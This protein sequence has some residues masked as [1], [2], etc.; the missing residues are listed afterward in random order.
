MPRC[1]SKKEIQKSLDERVTYM[2]GILMSPFESYRKKVIIYCR[3]HGLM[4]VYPGNILQ[5]HWCKKCYEE[6]IKVDIHKFCVSRALI[7][8]NHDTKD[9]CYDIGCIF[10]DKSKWS[11]LNNLNKEPYCLNCPRYS[12]QTAKEL[13]YLYNC[14]CLDYNNIHC[15]FNSIWICLSCNFTF[16]ES[17]KRAK[18]GNLC[19][20][21]KTRLNLTEFEQKAGEKLCRCLG[22]T[23]ISKDVKLTYE[24][25]C[26]DGKYDLNVTEAKEYPWC[27]KCNLSL[28]LDEIDKTLH[29]LKLDYEIKPE[30][31][32][33]KHEF[34]FE[35]GYRK[36]KYDFMVKKEEKFTL[37][38]YDPEE[39][40]KVTPNIHNSYED[41]DIKRRIEM[42]SAHF[43][44][45]NGY[46]HVR[47]S[48]EERKNIREHI[49]KGLD[50]N[51]KIYYSN[52][53]KYKF[54][55]DKLPREIKIRSKN[56]RGKEIIIIKYIER[57][58]A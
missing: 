4:E 50:S 29:D 55:E 51:E 25:L 48:H 39:F 57:A 58:E 5:G 53:I 1:E 10:C 27:K 14:Q 20:Y 7:C 13:A 45:I 16:E 21:C 35:K 8:H 33:D 30:L 11:S 52:P 32:K 3:T 38:T 46:V 37:I 36:I 44:R 34:I 19:P 22:I 54:M 26:C 41:F 23:N 15:E 40:F 28:G 17:L 6:N 2:G 24:C 43:S 47:I 56:N 49:L 31:I 42:D 9:D 12:L 18:D